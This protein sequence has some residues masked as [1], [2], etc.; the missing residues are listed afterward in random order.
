MKQNSRNRS[1]HPA[2]TVITLRS[3]RGYAATKLDGKSA[4]DAKSFRCQFGEIYDVNSDGNNNYTH[5]I[6]TYFFC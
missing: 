4:R 2:A 1:R 6:L 3:E 5:W